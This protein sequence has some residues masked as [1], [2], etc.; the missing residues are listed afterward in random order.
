MVNVGLRQYI[1]RHIA[2]NKQGRGDLNK[3]QR[4]MIW[5]RTAQERPTCRQHAQAFVQP[6]DTTAAQ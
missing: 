3:Y 5:Q 6:R 1:V 4:D 2:S